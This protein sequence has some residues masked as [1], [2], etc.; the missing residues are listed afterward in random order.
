[1]IWVLKK[2]K[3]TTMMNGGG[4]SLIKQQKTPYETKKYKMTTITCERED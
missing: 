1:V 4:V 2:N 3:T